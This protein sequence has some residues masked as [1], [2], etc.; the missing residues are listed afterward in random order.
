MTNLTGKYLI[1]DSLIGDC[2]YHEYMAGV[3]HGKKEGME[4]A[5]MADELGHIIHYILERRS[6]NHE[7]TR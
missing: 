4:H 6:K 2:I 7:E 1:L 5:N 3:Y